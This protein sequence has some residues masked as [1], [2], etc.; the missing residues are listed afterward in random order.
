MSRNLPKLA[1]MLLSEYP[2]LRQDTGLMRAYMFTIDFLE[3]VSK[4]TSSM[5]K[6]KQALLQGLVEA[7]KVNEDRLNQYILDNSEKVLCLK[8][9]I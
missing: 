4:E 8:I 3:A 6:E 7:A 2:V 9:H 1:E 5:L